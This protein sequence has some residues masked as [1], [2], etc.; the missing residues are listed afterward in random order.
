[1][2]TDTSVIPT[3]THIFIKHFVE[4]C[5]CYDKPV[6]VFNSSKG[7][8]VANKGNE[9]ISS[10]LQVMNY[11]RGLYS[12]RE[13]YAPQVAVFFEA[14][15]DMAWPYP[16][17]PDPNVILS[18]GDLLGEHFNALVVKIREITSTTQYKEKMRKMLLNLERQRQSAFLLVDSL[19]ET[20]SRL[21]V[22]RVDLF[23][24]GFT[25]ERSV[26]SDLKRFLRRVDDDPRFHSLLG[27]IAKLEFGET[28][29]LHAHLMVF[30]D[31]SKSRKG[32]HLAQQLINLW[33]EVI[34]DGA[35]GY[36]CNA[37]ADSYSESGINMVDH[38]DTTKRGHLLTA[39][40]YFFK[41]DQQVLVKSKEKDR[42]LFMSRVKR[43]QGVRPGRPRMRS[44][45]PRASIHENKAC[46]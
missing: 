28:R 40:R 9:P 35:H 3:V 32:G 34:G 4:V 12:P 30:L 45:M 42:T 17:F 29:G 6:F 43:I 37:K 10:Y 44:A 1:M 31:G 36:N 5:Q 7:I 27:Y 19:F 38:W 33:M 11:M 14:C 41:N 23:Y 20:H 2:N 21:L 25:A 26:S 8:L 16:I 39:L 46:P 15:I 18:E 22:L 24:R 13:F